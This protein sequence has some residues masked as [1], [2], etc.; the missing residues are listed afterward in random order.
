[1]KVDWAKIRLLRPSETFRP[2]IWIFCRIDFYTGRLC[3]TRSMTVLTAA[4]DCTGSVSRRTWSEYN[5]MVFSTSFAREPQLCKSDGI[6]SAKGSII[7][8]NIMGDKGQPCLVPFVILNN[9]DRTPDVKTLVAGLEYRAP[10]A[11]LMKPV[12]LNFNTAHYLAPVH[13]VE[14]LLHI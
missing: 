6:D 7:R 3:Q 4:K 12:N 14:G 13:P 10:I 2:I 1:M 9:W 8:T 11:S 5:P